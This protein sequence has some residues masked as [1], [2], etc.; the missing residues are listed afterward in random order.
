MSIII[1]LFI[2]YA[3]HLYFEMHNS[4]IFHNWLKELLCFNP[5]ILSDALS[6]C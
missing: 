5:V 3:L 2:E 1:H 6:N 4:F